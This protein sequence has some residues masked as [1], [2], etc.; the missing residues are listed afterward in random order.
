MQKKKTHKTLKKKS[1]RR[2]FVEETQDRKRL[3]GKQQMK[4]EATPETSDDSL[5]EDLS[6]IYDDDQLVDIELSSMPPPPKTLHK[7]TRNV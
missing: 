6:Y 7:P 3:K 4:R 1:V 2:C 5:E